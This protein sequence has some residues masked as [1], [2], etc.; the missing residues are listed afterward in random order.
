MWEKYNLWLVLGVLVIVAAIAGIGDRPG[1]SPATYAGG[2]ADKV[3]ALEPERSLPP[4]EIVQWSYY[5][6]PD[7]AGRGAVIWQGEVRNNTDDYVEVVWLQA[8]FYDADG[9]I[10]DTDRALVSGLAPGA[11]KSFKG[12]ATYFGTEKSGT[13]IVD[14]YY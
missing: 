5:L 11:K 12:Y 8:T 10:T 6:D 9:V 1:P 2:E 7:F 4:I 14:S 3:A 13:V